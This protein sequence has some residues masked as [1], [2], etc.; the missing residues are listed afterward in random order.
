VI[1]SLGKHL[2]RF[3]HRWVPDPFAL[4]LVLTLLTLVLA[5]ISSGTSPLELIGYWGGRLKG[6][7]VL[8]GEKGFWKLLTFAM[9]MCLIL[10]T[11]FALASSPPVEKAVDRLAGLPRT[12]GQAIALTAVVAMVAALINWGLGLIVGALLAR[13]VAQATHRRGVKVHYPLLGAAGYTG[14]LV[15]HGGLSASAPLKI[16]QA[17]DLQEILG[18]ADITPITLNDTLLSGLNVSVNL[19]LLLAV[20]LLLVAMAPRSE[21]EITPITMEDEDD[22]TGESPDGSE[23]TP[24]ERLERSPILAWLVALLALGYLASYLSHVGVGRADLNTINLFFLAIG[25]ALHGSPRAYADAISNG[26]RGCAGIILQFPFYGGIMGILAL[27]GV[28]GVLA[29]WIAQV[30]GPNTFAPFT[31]L[32]A[33]LVNLF[34]PS[35][36]GQWAIQGPLV[37]QAAEQLGVPLG[38][39][40]MAFAYG[41]AW[42]NMLQPFWALPLLA[43]TGLKA[44]EIVGYTAALMLLVLP[45]YLV[46]FALF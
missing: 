25:L 26:A 30:S 37:V 17:K 42:T 34:V 44:R 15:W 1:R 20:P 38:K 40:V 2:S 6:G 14:L 27:S 35:G 7:E 11:G 36:G 46:C 8:G 32:S 31:F 10:V 21:E 45:L 29:T 24:A 9:Q 43:I 5:W 13:G 4:A 18:R 3:A 22:T 28:M 12:Q 33:G 39:A 16:T 23:L 41:D 19:L